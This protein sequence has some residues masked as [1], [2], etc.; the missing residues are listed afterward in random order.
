MSTACSTTQYPIAEQGC[1]ISGRS[2]GKSAP[3]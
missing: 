1:W 2:R 3:Y